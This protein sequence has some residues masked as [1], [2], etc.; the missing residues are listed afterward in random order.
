MNTILKKIFA[1]VKYIGA[2]IQSNLLNLIKLT[3]IL[4]LKRFEKTMCTLGLKKKL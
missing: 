2:V 4:I 1:I 3:K